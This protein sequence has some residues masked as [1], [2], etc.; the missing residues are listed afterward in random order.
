MQASDVGFVGQTRWRHALTR[1]TLGF[2]KSESAGAVVLIAA[3]VAA[4]VWVGLDASSYDALWRTPLSVR[5]GGQELGLT[6]REW[7]NSGLMSFF[8][9]VVGLEARREFDLGELRERRR[10]LLPLLAGLG[11]MVVP[12]AIYLAVTSGTAAGHGWGT[13][14]STDTALALGLLTLAGV[15]SAA[16]RSFLLTVLVVD[17]LA[18]LTVIAVVYSDHVSVPA[19]L[20]A[21]ALLGIVAVVRAFRVRYGLVYAVLGAAAWVALLRSGIDPVAAGLVLGLLTWAYPASR[22]DLE[23]ATD[24]VRAFREQPTAALARSARVGL[25]AAISPNDRFQQL[26]SNWVTFLAVPVFALANIGIPLTAEALRRAFTSPVT[27]AVVAGYVIGKPVAVVGISWLVGVLSRGRLRAPVGWAAVAG[28]GIMAGVGFTVSLLIATLAFTG[29]DLE[30][31]KLGILAAAVIAY[32]LSAAV[33][34]LIA[35]LPELVG[36]R[37]LLGTAPVIVDLLDPVDPDRDHLRGPA[38]APV[39][40][41]E[42]G[43]FECPYCGLAES[44]VREL[45]AERGDV[46]Y[47][48]RHLPLTDVHPRAWLAAEAAEAAAAQGRFWE[49]HDLLMD[50]QDALKPVDLIGHAQAL[51]LDVERFRSD[52]RTHAG[53]ERVAEDVASAD[54]SGVSGTPTFFVNGRRHHGAYDIASLTADVRAARARAETAV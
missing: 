29:A 53:R 8:F 35:M 25:G 23:T 1:R 5:L 28:G 6:L 44:V 16:L 34:R 40:V 15:R 50:H 19:L 3:A 4:L 54:R 17:D 45:L 31:A 12:V 22:E 43:D 14:M 18:A 2:L 39:T 41:V 30:A 10:L 47:V 36:E 7:V 49:M 9:F 24:L 32:G 33:F 52:L 46:R 48:W 11:G 37:A 13:V 21:V 20:V 26:Y 27:L 51:G 38:D 42:Y